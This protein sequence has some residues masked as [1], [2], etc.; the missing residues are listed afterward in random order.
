MQFAVLMLVELGQGLDDATGVW[1]SV[2]SCG[3]E[4]TEVL[5]I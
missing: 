2:G 5:G 1:A 4:S 3:I